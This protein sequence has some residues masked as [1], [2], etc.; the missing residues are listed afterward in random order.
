MRTRRARKVFSPRTQSSWRWDSGRMM[1]CTGFLTP[2]GYEVYR[3]GDCQSPRK[4]IDAV[5]DGYTI[6]KD[7]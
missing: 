6:A 7:L 1:S 3:I 5:R 2:E 4:I